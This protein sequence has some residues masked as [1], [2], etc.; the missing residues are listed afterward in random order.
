[1][2]HIE[3]VDPR[4]VPE[5]GPAEDPRVSRFD[6]PESGEDGGFGCVGACCRPKD[7][8]TAYENLLG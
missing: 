2:R 3:T 4:E 5:S 6:E 1:M 8:G 7:R